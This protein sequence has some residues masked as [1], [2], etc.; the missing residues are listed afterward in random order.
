MNIYNKNL[1][2]SSIYI[3][4]QLLFYLYCS[5]SIWYTYI[6]LVLCFLTFWNWSQFVWRS[7]KNSGFLF[8]SRLFY[9]QSDQSTI[10]TCVSL[11]NQ[12]TIHNTIERHRG[13]REKKERKMRDENEKKT[14]INLRNPALTK[15]AQQRLRASFRSQ[16]WNVWKER[17]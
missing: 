17:K 4:L 16:K 5:K 14:K 1:F 7:R 9:H 6:I 3:F 11:E 8:V 10:V 15:W 13:N 12:N 2:I